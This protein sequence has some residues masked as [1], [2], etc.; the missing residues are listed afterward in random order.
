[1]KKN[2]R[3]IRDEKGKVLILVLLVLVVGGLVL[4]PLLGLAS[5]G[6]VAGEV[7]ERKTAELYAADAGV[8]DAMWKIMNPDV[9]GLGH[10]ECGET[11]WSYTYPEEGDP[12]FEVNGKTVVVTI[13]Y[14]G[15][16]VFRVSSTASRDDSDTTVVSYVH[17]VYEEGTIEYD[18]GAF[19]GEM[20]DDIGGDTVV[21]GEGDL[22]VTGNIEDSATV[23]V[24]GDLEVGGNIEG[25]SEVYVV[26]DL[27]L[28]EGFAN[29]EDQV[30]ICVGGN[31]IMEGDKAEVLDNVALYVEGDLSAK[32]ILDGA[33]VCV[34]GSVTVGKIEDEAIVCAGNSLTVTGPGGIEGGYLYIGL[35]GSYTVLEG[36][37]DPE[38]SD[39]FA[40]CPLCSPSC[41]DCRICC[42]CPLV[43]ETAG[44]GSWSDWALATYSINS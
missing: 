15:E 12:A 19:D 37:D 23:Y 35:T 43:F 36:E 24:E 11:T 20:I 2:M 5:T 9:S 17:G 10:G 38:V 33:E 21:Y 3:V 41:P 39:I 44:E 31:V 8:E 28:S 27:I 26:G 1:M 32:S 14:L 29:I 30:I 25:S 42:E 18:Y 4:T 22:T 16:G 34:E 40:N 7:Y 6:V 13:D